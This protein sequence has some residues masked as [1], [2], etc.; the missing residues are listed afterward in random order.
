MAMKPFAIIVL[1]ILRKGNALSTTGIYLGL[2]TFIKFHYFK[3][4]MISLFENNGCI[5]KLLEDK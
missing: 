2:N 5:R 1:L 4:L 3:T